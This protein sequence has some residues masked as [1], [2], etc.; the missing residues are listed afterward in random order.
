MDAKKIK[1]P[2]THDEFK[3]LAKEIETRYLHDTAY[4]GGLF[5]DYIVYVHRNS[6]SPVKFGGIEIRAYGGLVVDKMSEKVEII[7]ADK[8]DQ[9][10]LSEL[11][12]S[13]GRYVTGGMIVDY[14]WVFKC[15]DEGEVV[16]VQDYVV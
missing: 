16:D 6:P 10:A 7:L 3:Q 11:R 13:I 4:T 14:R 12:E 2:T 8:G 9:N 1:P 15:V 5:R